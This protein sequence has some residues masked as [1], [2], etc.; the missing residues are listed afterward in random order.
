M[1]SKKFGIEHSNFRFQFASREKTLVQSETSKE[2]MLA[3][4]GFPP[5]EVITKGW[6]VQPLRTPPVVRFLSNYLLV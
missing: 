5:D 6:K 2:T 4:S 1:T 3:L